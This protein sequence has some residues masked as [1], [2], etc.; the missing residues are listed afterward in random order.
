VNGFAADIK[1]VT[2]KLVLEVCRDFEIVGPAVKTTPA[3]ALSRPGAFEEV[4]PATLR[5]MDRAFDPSQP[6]TD[7]EPEPPKSVVRDN[8]PRR[9]F[10][11]V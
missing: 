5:S 3:R 2:R 4:T 1:P 11:F 10:S 6:A 7:A 8:P 9:R